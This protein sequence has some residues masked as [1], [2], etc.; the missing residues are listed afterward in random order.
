MVG[1][2][3]VELREKGADGNRIAD[4]D[5]ASPALLFL[6]LLARG[7]QHRSASAG[8]VEVPVEGCGLPSHLREGTRT[9][10]NWLVLAAEVASGSP[11][12]PLSGFAFALV[13]GSH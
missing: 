2:G 12:I 1:E 8:P 6:I 5:A 4:R 7:D 10:R 3:G 9:T 11:V 13:P